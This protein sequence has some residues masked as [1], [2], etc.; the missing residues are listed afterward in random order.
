MTPPQKTDDLDAKLKEEESA[1]TKLRVSV[2]RQEVPGP[3][4]WRFLES[5]DV[6]RVLFGPTGQE[7]LAQGSPWETHPNI[8]SPEG[9]PHFQTWFL[10][11]V[12]SAGASRDEQATARRRV[13]S[14][15]LRPNR[16]AGVAPPLRV[17]QGYPPPCSRPS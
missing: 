1:L 12:S 9:A 10:G 8:K 14:E 7:N 5:F 6:G 11:G 13:A 15:R 2:A 3:G 16:A 17:P 4:V